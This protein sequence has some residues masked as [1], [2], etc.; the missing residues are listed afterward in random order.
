MRK[1]KI[2]LSF[3]AVAIGLLVAGIAF[4]FYQSTKIISPSK[5]KQVTVATPTPTP[6]PSIFLSISE[7]LDEAVLDSRVVK[8]SGKTT[9]DATIVVLTSSGDQQVLNP[10]TT[11]DF[12]TT[13]TIDSGQNLLEITA[14]GANGEDITVKKTVTF[15]TEE[16]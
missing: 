16:F 7:P 1:E 13:V 4:Y 10:T 8:I 6:R 12:S 2:V 14:I 5:I 15:S 11:G 9:P 3:I